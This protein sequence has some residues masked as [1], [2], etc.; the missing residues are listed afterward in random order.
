MSNGIKIRQNEEKCIAMLAAQRQLYNDAK[1]L[2]LVLILISVILPF[3]LSFISSISDNAYI[4]KSSYM[5]AIVALFLSF[6]MDKYI[7]KQKELAATI[8]QQFDIYTYT[9]PWDTKIFGNNRNL[10]QEIA[11]NSKFIMN[12]T[13]KKQEL[14][15]WYA[16]EN[17]NKP[18]LEGILSCQRE[19]YVWDIGLRKRFKIASIITILALSLIV[20]VVGIVHSEE[21]ITVIGHIA[22]IAPMLEW[23][24]STVKSINQD[25][26]HL[27]DLDE[28]INDGVTKSMDDL[29]DIQKLLFEHRKGC[30]TIPNFLY[31]IFK[32]ND[33][34]IAHRTA[35]L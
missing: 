3:G 19:N 32:N 29:Q 1:G 35:S 13:N 22:F 9:M 11:R 24:L 15:D 16:K 6:I 21:F 33:E 4:D 23:L 31:D 2:N 7:D 10:S 18:L 12:N 25:I 14:Y 30:Y 8:Q 28:L 20:F 27:N 34:D 26:E 17:D 5:V